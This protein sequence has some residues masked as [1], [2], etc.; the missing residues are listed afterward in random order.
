MTD[1]KWIAANPGVGSC[2]AP[3]T[4]TG[5]RIEELEAEIKR[6]R[7]IEAAARQYVECYQRSGDLRT[8]RAALGVKVTKWPHA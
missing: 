1:E 3:G 5:D 4:Y 7:E 8:L 6:L 2:D